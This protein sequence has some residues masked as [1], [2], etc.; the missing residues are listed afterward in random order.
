MGVLQIRTC[1]SKSARRV[2]QGAALRA[3]RLASV[4]S[5]SREQPQVLQHTLAVVVLLGAQ[6]SNSCRACEVEQSCVILVPN[7]GFLLK[8][9]E[10]NTGK[11]NPFTI[12]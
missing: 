2:D 11:G 10:N 3:N 9:D 8:R 1:S 12:I 4:A 6:R 7:N 5:L